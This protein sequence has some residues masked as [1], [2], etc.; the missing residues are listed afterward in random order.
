MK[1]L[2][3]RAHE[4]RAAALDALSKV[5][6]EKALEDFYV[7]FLAKKGSIP[8]LMTLMKDAED[9]GAGC[10]AD[11]ADKTEKDEEDKKPASLDE[12]EKELLAR[13]GRKAELVN[14]LTPIIGA[15]DSASMTEKEVAA[16]A[17]KKLNIKAA[18]DEAPA[19]LKGYLAGYKPAEKRVTM[20]SAQDEAVNA[21]VLNDFKEGK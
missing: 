6:D 8:G 15:I 17:C 14:K 9:K 1:N 18:M 10:D 16:Y 2:I 20:K 19:V 3:E 5:I 11:E 7:S 12:M 21:D 4:A 13:I